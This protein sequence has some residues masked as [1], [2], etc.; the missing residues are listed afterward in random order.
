MQPVKSCLAEWTIN[1]LKNRDIFF[2]KIQSIDTQPDSAD[3]VINYKDGR[4][5]RFLVLESLNDI[6]AA[7]A[8][9]DTASYLGIATVNSNSNFDI[10]IEKW[11]FMIK[12]SNL[13]IYFVNPFSSLEKKWAVHPSTHNKVASLG[14]MKPGLRALFGTAEPITAEILAQKIKAQT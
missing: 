12:Y 5:Q 10:L 14:S 6:E 13:I 8:E 1:F 11:E 2:R 4:K 3:F 7:L 9:F